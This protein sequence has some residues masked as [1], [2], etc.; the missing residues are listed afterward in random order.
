MDVFEHLADPVRTV[1]QLR[2]AL[3][4]DRLL[5]LGFVRVWQDQWLWG[6]QVFEK[7][8]SGVTPAPEA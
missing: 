7:G 1:E 2:E 3:T 5:P 6:H 4:F 8:G